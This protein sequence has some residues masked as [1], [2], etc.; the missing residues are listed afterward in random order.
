MRIV[1]LGAALTQAPQEM[2]NP[3]R[4]MPWTLPARP[5]TTLSFPTSNDAQQIVSSPA[6]EGMSGKT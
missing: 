6:A 1:P 4:T 5:M 3:Q 2:H